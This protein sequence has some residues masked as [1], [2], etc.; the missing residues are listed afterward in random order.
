MERGGGP[1]RGGLYRPASQLNRGRERACSHAAVADRRAGE[2]QCLYYPSQYLVGGP[3]GFKMWN[4][5]T[6][7]STARTIAWHISG[8]NDRAPITIW[9]DGRSEPSKY[10]LHPIGGWASGAWEGDTLKV[11]E[12]HIKAG[13]LRRNGARLSDQAAITFSL[14]SGTAI[15]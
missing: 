5:D 11:K 10:A 13:Y 3:F 12:T 9:M 6:E 8:T 14:H 1:Q 2:R 7:R 15:C 4:E